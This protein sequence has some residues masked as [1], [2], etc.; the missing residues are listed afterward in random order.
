MFFDIVRIGSLGLAISTLW[1]IFRFW[2]VYPKFQPQFLV[3]SIYLLHG[4]IYYALL[5][6]DHLTPLN[7]LSDSAYTDW[8]AVLRFHSFATWFFVATMFFRVWRTKNGH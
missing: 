8:G 2:K 1:I 3:I 5:T 4:M 7:F 6:L